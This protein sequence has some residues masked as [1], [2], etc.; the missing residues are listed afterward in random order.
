MCVKIKT[1]A[2]NRQ[3]EAEVI[4]DRGIW[5][6]YAALLQMFEVLYAPFFF[7]LKHC[8]VCIK[9]IITCDALTK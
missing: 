9:L 2:V 7:S 4:V 5:T 3:S 6:V 1:V 8:V